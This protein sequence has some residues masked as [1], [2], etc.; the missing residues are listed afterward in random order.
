[1]K[2]D[3]FINLE[4]MSDLPDEIETEARENG[5]SSS[6]AKPG[7]SVFGGIQSILIIAFLAASLFTL[8]TPNNLSPVRRWKGFS[9]HGRQTP[10]CGAAAG[11]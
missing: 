6:P 8:F 5:K 2:N 4:E 11:R 1:M 3:D 7:F 9:R 10:P